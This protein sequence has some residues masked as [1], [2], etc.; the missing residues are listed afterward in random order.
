MLEAFT[1]SSDSRFL[2]LMIPTKKKSAR[3]STLEFGAINLNEFPQVI[4][5][6]LIVKKSSWG[7]STN[8]CSILW[9]ICKSA[10][11]RQSYKRSFS[12][13]NKRLSHERLDTDLIHNVNYLCTDSILLMRHTAVGDHIGEQYFAKGWTN[14]LNA[15]IKI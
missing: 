12:K 6:L 4:L 1:I 11:R 14:T 9:H 3:A 8:W 5:I 10:R 2:M 15:L 7:I 13:S